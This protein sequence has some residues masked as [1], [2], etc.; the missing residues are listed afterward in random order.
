MPEGPSCVQ[1]PQLTWRTRG[2]WLHFG[3]DDEAGHKA[4]PLREDHPAQTGRSAWEATAHT[5]SLLCDDGRFRN[6][7]Q[8]CLLSWRSQVTLHI[9]SQAS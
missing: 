8:Q 6:D 4:Q 1:R 2:M 5:A 7:T 9:S 3:E